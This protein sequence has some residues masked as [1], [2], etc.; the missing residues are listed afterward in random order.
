M[1]W[2]KDWFDREEYDLVYQRRDETEAEMMVDLIASTIH[3]PVGESV[4]DVA[5]GRGRHAVEL[6]RRGFDVVGV[7]LSRRAIERARLR[8][9]EA[10]VAVR[11]EQ[12]DMRIPYCDGCF[13][14]VVNLFTAFGYFETREEHVEALRSMAA[15]LAANGW[16][17]QDF[18]N[19][20]H[21]R[22][23]L[24][25]LDEHEA[26]G[27][28]IIQ[29]RWIEN[30]R[31]NKHIHLIRDDERHSFFESVALFDLADMEA[32]YRHAGL[33]IHRIFG[34]YDGA[35]YT[36]KSPRLILFAQPGHDT[37]DSQP[38]TPAHG[39]GM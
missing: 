3:L 17:V 2:Y 39:N 22:S 25:P 19:A 4:L 12:A 23:T 21:V 5:C 30:G 14:C 26:D 18:L 33:T 31:V 8:A 35:P 13:G 11:F 15:S 32:M 36:P 34:S 37:P 9:H 24:R 7:D 16:F 1:A 38:D 27:V 29:E 20:D 6:A 10:G 28:R